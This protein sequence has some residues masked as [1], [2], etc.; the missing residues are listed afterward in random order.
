MKKN[1][2]FILS[3]IILSISFVSCSSDNDDEAGTG[4]GTINLYI[5]GNKMNT[6]TTILLSSISYEKP[7]ITYPKSEFSIMIMFGDDSSQNAF[8]NFEGIDLDGLKVGDDLVNLCDDYSYQISYGGNEYWLNSK[9]SWYNE[10]ASGKGKFVVK[11]LN[12]DKTV[13]NI[14]F[15]DV[16]LPVLGSSLK[17]DKTKII[18]IK[19]NM[20]YSIDFN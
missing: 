10:F 18:D 16:K 9:I 7:T 2:L 3:I 14:E 5:D 1:L 17:P 6:N 19:G 15:Q 12:S 4:V 13:V 11:E 8:F 20:N